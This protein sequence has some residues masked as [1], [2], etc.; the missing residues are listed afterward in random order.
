[1]RQDASSQSAES[2]PDL[3]SSA[4]RQSFREAARKVADSLPE[5]QFLAAALQRPKPVNL[6]N[7]PHPLIPINIIPA[8]ELHFPMENST[9][10]Q[11]HPSTMFFPPAHS[12][13][14]EM[15]YSPSYFGDSSSS[16]SAKRKRKVEHHQDYSSN[17][18]SSPRSESTEEMADSKEIVLVAMSDSPDPCP[19]NPGSNQ[20]SSLSSDPLHDD[21]NSP[22]PY[23]ST[24]RQSPQSIRN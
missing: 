5:T 1:M 19:S 15:S 22:G 16:E 6:T 21:M 10:D 13:E 9:A 8:S 4:S 2:S 17:A 11:S 24:T 14:R 23:S 12:K 7:P 18:C 3:T 20:S